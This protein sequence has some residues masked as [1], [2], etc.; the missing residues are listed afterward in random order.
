MLW[1]AA[2]CFWFVGFLVYGSLISLTVADWDSD[3]SGCFL[4]LVFSVLLLPASVVVLLAH[5]RRN[6]FPVSK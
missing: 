6:K 5:S 3:F 4:A 2:T 1:F